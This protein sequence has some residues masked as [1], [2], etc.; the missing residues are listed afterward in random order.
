MSTMTKDERETLHRKLEVLDDRLVTS[1]VKLLS[2]EV[3]ALQVFDWRIV[4]DKSA[5][6]TT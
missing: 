1:L 4:V 2:G 3:D 5:T 6:V